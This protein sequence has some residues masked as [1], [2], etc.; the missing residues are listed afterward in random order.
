MSLQ[1]FNIFFYIYVFKL[2]KYKFTFNHF[3]VYDFNF[4]TLTYYTGKIQYNTTIKS[5]LLK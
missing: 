3:V 4:F 1:N 5:Q 2:K